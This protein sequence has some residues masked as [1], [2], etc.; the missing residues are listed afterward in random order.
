MTNEELGNT[1]DAHS[2]LNTTADTLKYLR[3]HHTDAYILDSLEYC[4]IGNK[5]AIESLM[6]NQVKDDMYHI[7]ERPEDE[8]KDITGVFNE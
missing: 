5:L 7:T 8:Y 6:G 4:S 3:R 2:C 1:I